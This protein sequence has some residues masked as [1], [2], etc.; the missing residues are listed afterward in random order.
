MISSWFDYLTQT[1][2][3]ILCMSLSYEDKA[4]HVVCLQ[5]EAYRGVISI[6]TK[7]LEWLY[8]D[9]HTTAYLMEKGLRDA[10]TEIKLTRLTLSETE[11]VFAFSLPRKFYEEDIELWWFISYNNLECRLDIYWNM[12][13]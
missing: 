11:G 4:L 2:R 1:V 6:D 5:D 10:R 7:K 3:R 12:T 9:R 13:I 8:E